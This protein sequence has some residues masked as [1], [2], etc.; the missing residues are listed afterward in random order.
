MALGKSIENVS[1]EGR[2][3]VADQSLVPNFSRETDPGY[4]APEAPAAAVDGAE[5]R[6]M[7]PQTT[8]PQDVELQSVVP[9]AVPT[10]APAV[11]PAAMPAAAAP[12]KPVPAMRTQGRKGMMAQLRRLSGQKQPQDR[13]S[14]ALQ[15]ELA[16]QAVRPVK[17]DLSESDLEAVPRPAPKPAEGRPGWLGRVGNWM[18]RRWPRRR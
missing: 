4:P 3:K 2:Y 8:A 16:L 18:R 5:A 11:V 12:A 9:A 17:N 14:I 6:T 7:A 1:G 15:R 10:I 13:Q